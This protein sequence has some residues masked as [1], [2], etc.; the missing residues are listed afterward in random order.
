VGPRA[1]LDGVAKRKIPCCCR[2]SNLGRPSYS[3]LNNILLIIL[4]IHLTSF[5]YFS[6]FCDTCLLYLAAKFVSRF[7][8]FRSLMQSFNIKARGKVVPVHFLTEHHAMKAY[9]WSGG[10]APRIL[11]LGSRWR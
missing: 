1:D 7:L 2:D 10:I 11:E 3:I 4:K 6:V 8:Y 5:V 9:W